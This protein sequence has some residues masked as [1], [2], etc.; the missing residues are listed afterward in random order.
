[1]SDIGIFMRCYPMTIQRLCVDE[2]Q[3]GCVGFQP[4]PFTSLAA[5]VEDLQV[6]IHFESQNW[7]RQA[8]HSLSKHHIVFVLVFKELNM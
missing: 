3:T 1:M 5:W 8:S 2:Q 6:T 7:K 4:F